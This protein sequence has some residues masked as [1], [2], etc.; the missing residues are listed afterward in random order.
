MELYR[1]A[2]YKKEKCKMTVKMISA[3]V[4]FLTTYAM[5]VTINHIYLFF[6]TCNRKKR[7]EAGP[8]LGKE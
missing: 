7:R 5:F 3:A 4:H 8:D 1:L 6:N 2:R